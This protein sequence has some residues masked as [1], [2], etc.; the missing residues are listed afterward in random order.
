[1]AGTDASAI[2][3]GWALF[4]QTH[5]TAWLSLSL[6]ITI[7]G[8]GLLAPL[9]GRLADRVDRRRLMIAC[10]VVSALLFSSLV[11]VHTPSVL[12]GVSVLATLSGVAYGP[13]AGAAIADL[14]GDRDL[15]WANGVIA[16]GGNVGRTAGRVAAGGLVAAVGPGA[17]FALDAVSFATSALLTAS[18]ASSFGGGLSAAREPRRGGLRAL[19]GHPVLRPLAASACVSTLVTSF[20]MTA[21]VPLAVELGGG[22]MAL[23]LLTAGWGTGMVAGS[24]VAGRVLHAGNEATGVLAGRATMAVGLGLVAL[25]P[26][27]LPTTLSYVLGG[28]GG[29]FMGVG[30]QSLILRRTAEAMRGRALAALDACRN[31]S[32]GAGVLAAGGVVGLLGPRPVYALVGLGVMLG[33]LPLVALVGRLG[34]LRALRAEPGMA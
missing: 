18:V 6:L 26:T 10:E 7:G 1:M 3:L 31:L 11:F 19:I 24:W 9:G 14:A 8:G 4:S 32:F 25:A 30:S 28:L 12:L 21:E 27:L 5:S 2:A 16:T 13:A 23:G 20:S 15:S 34:G 22:A 17:V 33:C 29:G